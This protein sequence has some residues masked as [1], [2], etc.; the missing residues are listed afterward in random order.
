DQP[1]NIH[2]TGCPH[3]CAQHY[4]GDIGLLGVKKGGVECYH[5]CVGG[6]FG[7]RAA[8]GR[9]VLQAVPF[10]ELKPAIEHMLTVYL[11]LRAEGESFQ[12]F[13]S[14]HDNVDLQHLLQYK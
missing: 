3:S 11:Q 9:Q 2:F 4:V 10:D 7:N 14:R 6:G 1:I 8:I 5:V 13:T 12:S